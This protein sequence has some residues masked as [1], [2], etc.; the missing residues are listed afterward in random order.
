VADRFLTVFEAL[1]EEHTPNRALPP[2]A[3]DSLL[4]GMPKYTSSA[5]IWAQMLRIAMS[6]QARGWGRT[7]FFNEVTKTERRKI[8]PGQ[9]RL[10]Q[11]Q[12]WLQLKACS[13]DGGHATAQLEK[14]WAQGEEHRAQL[15]FVTTEDLVNDA[16]GKAWEWED[17]I[18]EGKD[19]LNDAEVAV[20]SYIIA[21][22]EKRR[23]T[24]VT[25]SCR[26]IAEFM[27]IPKSTVYRALGTLKERGFV[28]QVS[29]G[30]WHKKPDLRLAAIYRL[31]DPENLRYG[32]RGGPTLRPD[33]WVWKEFVPDRDADDVVR[34]RQRR[35]CVW[36]QGLGPDRTFLAPLGSGT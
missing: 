10:T 19:A 30:R 31:G 27:N 35:I 2:W 24:R 4:F 7:E 1:S 11:H 13:R 14:A 36:G 9:K 20:M 8:R 6:A 12:L 29:K 28:Q 15:G 33:Q 21:F 18:A 5:T 32:G 25:C 16:I 17:R 22:V 26:E 3:I 34:A 23:M